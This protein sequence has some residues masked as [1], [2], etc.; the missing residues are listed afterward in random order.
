[1]L[2]FDQYEIEPMSAYSAS[3]TSNYI[4]LLDNTINQYGTRNFS[5]TNKKVVAY[6]KASSTYNSNFN[7]ILWD[8]ETYANILF[9]NGQPGRINKNV[10]LFSNEIF[11]DSIP[12]NPVDIH[13]ANGG[14]LVWNYFINPSP[15]II[16]TL[17]LTSGEN[18]TASNNGQQISDNKWLYSFP[19][20]SKYK[21]IN[22]Y[23]TPQISSENLEYYLSLNIGPS[24]PAKDAGWRAWKYDSGPFGTPS[25]KPI[26]IE[27]DNIRISWLVTTQSYPYNNLSNFDTEYS[28]SRVTNNNLFTH[29]GG[30]IRIEPSYLSDTS[31]LSDKD[32]LDD[33][34]GFGNGSSANIIGF[35]YGLPFTT[36]LPPFSSLIPTA[37]NGS[38]L[39]NFV[40]SNIVRGYKYGLYAANQTN[41]KCIYRLGRYGQFRDMLEG[42][43]GTAT[44]TFQ[45]IDPYGQP[46]RKNIFYPLDVNFV[47]GSEIYAQ[48]KDYVSATNPSYNLYDSGIYDYHYRSGQPFTD[49]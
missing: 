43:I 27:T 7:F 23:L 2:V 24:I 37:S 46:I 18:L 45:G 30:S 3:Y 25:S 47:T 33:Y 34:F 14:V 5:L 12:P 26:K 38:Y 48:A 9:K 6:D 21:N 41:I 49:R 19:F 35:N 39:M 28:S 17:I 42:R 1:M 8:F 13:K 29:R 32:I 4:A 10:N 36:L 15:Y 20:Q 44:Y 16:P 11:Y 31:F 40:Y 22:K